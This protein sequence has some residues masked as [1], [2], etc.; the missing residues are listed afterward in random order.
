M[1]GNNITIPLNSMISFMAD[2][3]I[4]EAVFIQALYLSLGVLLTDVTSH[5]TF[6][7]TV[8]KLSGFTISQKNAYDQLKKQNLKYIPCDEPTWYDYFLDFKKLEWV[9]WRKAVPEYIHDDMI[10]FDDILIPTVESTR[11]IWILKLI[12]EVLIIFF[13]HMRTQINKRYYFY[14]SIILEVQFLKR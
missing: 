11:L 2:M 10:K 13:F 8:K 4:I 14:F 9:A 7:E 6:D 12:N 5:H 1:T 3:G